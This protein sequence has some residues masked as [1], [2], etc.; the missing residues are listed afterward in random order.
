MSASMAAY[1]K[2]S[3]LAEHDD[4]MSW[5][6]FL[7]LSCLQGGGVTSGLKKVTD[8]MKTKNRADRSGAVP[9]SAPSSSTVTSKGA[10]LFINY[11]ASPSV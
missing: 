1:C 8:D 2:S 11:L 5:V 4:S 7:W 10:F 9:S 3:L 6:I